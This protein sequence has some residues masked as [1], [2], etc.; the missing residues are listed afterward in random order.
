MLP[1]VAMPCRLNDTVNL[2]CY[3]FMKADVSMSQWGS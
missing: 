1:I 2:I 3:V